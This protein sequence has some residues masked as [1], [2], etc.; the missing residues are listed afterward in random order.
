LGF[1]VLEKSSKKIIPFPI[2][3]KDLTLPSVTHR[4]EYG[5]CT[6]RVEGFQKK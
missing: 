3:T 1:D 2:Y 5:A 4:G 6:P